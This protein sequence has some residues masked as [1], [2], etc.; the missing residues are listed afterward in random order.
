MDADEAHNLAMARAVRQVCDARLVVDANC[1]WTVDQALRL[2]PALAD[3]G[4]EWIEQP[5]P[6]D[7]LDGL[8]HLYERS[9]LPIFADEPVRLARDIP[10]L[11]GCVHG[12]NIKVMKSGG[13]REALR[14]IAVA[15]AHDLQVMLGCMI[16]TSL[17][18][19]PRPT[20]LPWS[21][22]PTWTVTWTWSTTRSSASRYNGA[23]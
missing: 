19:R 3:L 8:R 21:I 22:G 1:S 17:G 13:L 23:N 14:I 6:E 4:I 9:P 10:R 15:R 18:S 2:I 5:L 11:A 7:D 20:C 16:E 12:V